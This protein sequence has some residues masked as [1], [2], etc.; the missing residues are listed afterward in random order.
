MF[1]S[2]NPCENKTCGPYSS[3]SLLNNVPTCLCI[4]GYSGVSGA[5][6]DIDECAAS[7]CAV[8]A[9]CVNEPGSFS[10]QCPAGSLGDPFK[11]GCSTPK[12]PP[13]CGPKNPCPGSEICVP[14]EYLGTSVCVCS[15]GYI[16]D[17]K[18]GLCRDMNEC[19]EA[20][21][22]RPVC[23]RNAVC[24][25][26]PGSYECACPPGFNGNPFS[27]CE[28]CNTLECQ[29]RPPYQIA[30][31]EC[32]L[33][34]C[35]TQGQCPGGAEC[36]NIAGGVSYCACPKGFRPKEDGYCEDVDECAESRHLCGPGAV[37]INHPGSYT[38]QC[39]PN[40]S[41][42]PLLGCTHARV[43]CSRDAD[44]D[45]PYER[46]V[47][48]ACV[49][50]APYYADV[51]D[52]HKCK[53]PCER[54]SCGINAQCTPADPPQCTC[55]AGYT[56]EATVGC[57]DVDECLGVSPCASSALCVNEK[58]GFKCVCPKGT[59][60]DPYTLGCVGS[61]SPRTECRVD[62]ECSPSL[63]CRGGACVDPCRSVECGAH[64]LCEP[65][66]HRASCRCELGYTE[67]LNGKCVSLCEGIVCAPGAA[68]IVTPAG[69]TCTCADGAR[70]NPF[71]GGACYPDLCSATQPCPALSVCVAGRCK[72]RCAGVVCGAGAQC[73][74]ALDRCVCPP[75]YVGDPEFNCVPPV[76]MPVCIPP[77]G[78]NAHCEYN[79]ESP[80]SSPG[81]DNICVCNSG[82][83]GNPYAGC[84][85]AGP[86][87]RGS[88][89]SGAGLCGPGAQCLETGGSVECQCPA[90]Y[91]GNPYV[92]CVDIDECWS[93]NTCGSNAVCINT[94]GSYDCRCKEGNAGN[95]FVACTPVAVVPHSCE[96]PAT[97]VCSKNAPC[98]SGYVCKN[99]R[100]TDLCANV[101]CGPRALCV[102]GQCLCPSDLI[103][104]PTDLTRG[105]QVKGQCA[106][107]LECKPNEICF[108][109]NGKTRMCVDSCAKI[110]CGPNAI[111]VGVNHVAS[112]MCQDGYQGVPSDL[113]IG[114]QPERSAPKNECTKDQ[115]CSRG[116]VCNQYPET[117]YRKCVNLCTSTACGA[118][119]VC[120]V[121]E[122][123]APVCECK[124]GYTWNALSSACEL[125]SLPQC[126][127]NK[128]C[129]DHL[130]CRPDAL[131]ILQ[132][133]NP[134]DDFQCPGNSTCI[135]V[136][137][138]GTCS[139]LPG[140]TG[141]PEV[142]A[143]CQPVPIDTCSSDQQCKEH[144]TCAK[145]DLTGLS[146]CQNSCDSVSCGVNAV[147]VVNNHEARCFCPPGSY[148]GDP[149]IEC[150]Q[151]PCVHN[152]DCST[153]HACDL[154]SHTCIPACDS[155]ACGT[156]AVCIPEDHRPVCHCPV[157][158]HPSP[159]PDIH[160]ARESNLCRDSNPCHPTARC[161][162][163]GATNGKVV[164][165]CPELSVGDPYK[166]GCVPQGQC[167]RGDADCPPS[168]RCSGGQCVS[169]CQ[170]ACGPNALC[171]AVGKRPVCA[172]PDGFSAVGGEA[173]VGCFREMSACAGDQECLA[174][175]EKCIGG[176]CRVACLSHSDCSEGERC[177]SS[178]CQSPCTSHSQCPTGQACQAG[179]CELGC[180][181][182]EEC[183]GQ[184]ICAGSKCIDP[185]TQEGICGP[186]ALCSTSNHTVSC[187]C[188]VGFQGHPEPQQGCV[189]T[190]VLCIGGRTQCPSGHECE[191]GVCKKTCSGEGDNEL[192]CAMGE[193]CIS[194]RC[195]KIC[196][197][198]ANCLSGE[199][200]RG[201]VCIPGC[202]SDQ[203][204]ATDQICA[205]S[206]CR[207]GPGFSLT[208][209]GCLDMDECL[210][211]PCHKSA[212]CIN[213][214]GSFR[215]VCKPNT[216]G[217][218][219]LNPGCVPA[220]GCSRASDCNATLSCIHR[221]C[222]DPCTVPENQCGPNALCDVT[223]HIPTCTCPEGYLGDPLNMDIGCFRVEC[224]HPSHCAYDRTCD[225]ETNRCINPCDKATCGNGVCK[226]ANHRAVCSCAPGFS[227]VNNDC[228]D[229]N[230]CDLSPCHPTAL[231]KNTAGSFVC[232]CAGGLIGDPTTSGCHPADVCSYD[233]QCP[234]SAACVDGRCRNPCEADEVCGRN[235]ECAVVNH[236]PRCTCVAG[237]VGD[238]K[239]GCVKLECTHS[240]DCGPS[241]VCVSS[242]CVDPCGLP[243]SCGQNAACRADK[244]AAVCTCAED[245]TGDPFLGC[246]RLLYCSGDSQCPTGTHCSNGLCSASCTSSRDCIGEQQCISGLC[247]PT[248]RSN[249]T[250]P[251]QHYCNSGL[252]VPE[253]Q[254]T[255]HDQCSAT[256]QCRSNDM[257]QM[258]CRPACEGILCGR[259]ALCTASDHHATCSCKPGYVGHPG[260]SMGTGPSSHSGHAG[261]KHGPGLSPGAT[262]HSSHS[263]GPVGCHRVECNS[264]ADCSGDKV[265]ED[266][267]CKISCLANNPCGP[268]ALCSAEKHKQICY[269]QPGYTGDAYFGCHLIDFCAAKPCGPGARCDNSRGSYKCLCPLGLVGDPYGAGC[270]SASQCTRDDQCPPG[271]HCVK[272]D[273]VPKCK[274]A[275][276]GV[277]C[278]PNADCVTSDHTS[279]CLC[280]NGYEGNPSDLT[281]GCRP[282]PL[283]CHTNNDCPANY[284]CYGELCRTSCQSDEECGLGEKCLQGQC[285]NP[286]ERQG[287]CGVN[288]LCNVLTHRKVCFCPRGFTGD[289]ETECVRMPV[290]CEVSK[291]CP[292]STQHVCKDNLCIPQCS[293]DN[294]CALNE[295][296]SNGTCVLTCLSHADCYPGGGSLCLANLCTR[297]CSADTDCPAALSCRS[298][299][300]VDPCSPAPCGPNAQC[301]VANHRPLCSCPAGLMGLPSANTACVRTPALECEENRQCKG[302]GEVCADG[303]CRPLCSSD[304]GCLSNE[305][306][307]TAAGVCKPLC[308]RDDDCS[309]GEVCRGLLCSPGCRS[310]TGCADNQ[311]C[312][313]NSCQDPCLSPTACGTNAQ[314]S[315]QHHEKQCLCPKP[316][317]GDPN[318]AC[319]PETRMCAIKRDCPSGS[320]CT[321]GVCLAS[322]KSDSNCLTDER[323][324]K[325]SC[326][327]ICNS[328]SKCDSGQICEDR[329]CVPGCRTDSVCADNQ[330]CVNKQC[331]DPCTLNTTCGPCSAC[332]TLNHGPQCT[333]P[334][335]YSGHPLL[336]CTPS[337]MRCDGACPCDE[338]SGY[339]ASM[340]GRDEECQ[341]GE[342]CDQGRCR[343]KCTGGVHSACP[344][345]QICSAGGV[346]Q[347]GCRVHSDC[348]Q[349]KSCI[350]GQC[351]DPCAKGS[352]GDNLRPTCGVDALCR[353]VEHRPV[354]LC[355]D[356]YQGDPTDR[357]E[358]Y[359]CK[360]DSDCEPGK[361]CRGDGVCRNP[362][363][364]SG[365]CG[366]NAQCRVLQRHAWRKAAQPG[367]PV[368]TRPSVPTSVG[369]ECPALAP[370]AVPGTPIRLVCV[371][372]CP[373][374]ASVDRMPT[375]PYREEDR[376]FAG[377]NTEDCRVTGCGRGALCTRD[378]EG[379]SCHCPSGTSGSP[380][381][382]CK[383]A[384]DVNMNSTGD[385][386][387]V[388]S[389]TSTI[390]TTT[391]TTTPT[392]YTSALPSVYQQQSTSTPCLTQPNL[393]QS[394]PNINFNH[395]K[396]SFPQDGSNQHQSN[397]SLFPNQGLPQD[398]LSQYNSNPTLTSDQMSS[399]ISWQI[400]RSNKRKK[401]VAETSPNLKLKFKSQ[402]PDN[403][404][405][406]KQHH[407][408]T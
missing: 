213:T 258:Q 191:D 303:R 259:N 23:G 245:Y 211:R 37:C 307:D 2:L 351:R 302:E 69:P 95:P 243:N 280:R 18:S 1:L 116:L 80:G 121:D 201:G 257:G 253:M 254:C 285:N 371:L 43:Q 117:G 272:T 396:Q 377:R 321:D 383:P 145:D 320:T 292:S 319:R 284:Y 200:C 91:K 301:S 247:Q 82:T 215:C 128:D 196:Y 59:T 270:V 295:K 227:L 286:C 205:G 106:N 366:V 65:Q 361:S 158:T 119:E 241:Q 162:D 71:P 138:E 385:L 290:P 30:S 289:P 174:G 161:E 260:P 112:C 113:N 279:S 224:S 92:Q 16:R 93:S 340:C 66:D 46:C 246:T 406:A 97:C 408:S 314:C 54:F 185:C 81:N 395:S 365:V 326:Q 63:Q 305:R 166:T 195:E 49:C 367:T 364:T 206:K 4:S 53:S 262:S 62:K 26:L 273:G 152:H 375:A 124:P 345:G 343:V 170:G 35:G 330:A 209:S 176:R 167:P 387:V 231:C 41:G 68:C 353:V 329:L 133:S 348:P 143:G 216:V 110:Q 17:P 252:C 9:V 281:V 354:C 392:G 238:P 266:H 308:H 137:H 242:K 104:N 180:R 77:C 297:G 400:V 182:N 102:Q 155:G 139:C 76:T 269:C 193:R 13:G 275:C 27:L 159:S 175:E 85:T 74:P 67:G 15:R 70:G 153:S 388:C 333:C 336:A 405:D 233:G 131:G 186:N 189:R 331:T 72:A 374:G 369:A 160:C 154:L 324:I 337:P 288:S 156:N 52:G 226:A 184:M 339:C 393:Y 268:N 225:P 376:S 118:N 36:V 149:N 90:G 255:T 282:R 5:C 73:D 335:G 140:F 249:T 370:Q 48:A 352:P 228:V 250:C 56:G 31:G 296:C 391:V 6:A 96:D 240:T 230:E 380:S 107:D 148:V 84:G 315:V 397:P 123:G 342:K 11:E 294:D 390:C 100:C 165:S 144:E 265:C 384:D 276:E 194:N 325:A 218:P 147:C 362:C 373:Q 356:N 323:C 318:I 341:C 126:T 311:A 198:A 244:H 132:C 404:S 39:P 135:S 14:D 181:Q 274:G 3:C 151:V 298:A 28:E 358:S 271:A 64:A 34:T 363:L 334:L 25:N 50:P 115:D 208:P 199:V 129:Q 317:Q 344:M 33:A 309:S 236:T 122:Q 168:S 350:D 150:R 278:G 316:L 398:I 192:S 10:C 403:Q 103:G 22:S 399:Q 188:P 32:T 328:D 256:E 212:S 251:A 232:S 382:E 355:P 202:S 187:S 401:N 378:E 357:C 287:A 304:G 169:V 142:R 214:P 219:Y 379:Y 173:R 114:C 237:T 360:Q 51:N 234:A 98:P 94:P 57:L 313:D 221:R 267:R 157:G 134:C 235:A 177:L 38:C 407:K 20:R 111:C 79:S 86:Q 164:C 338:T 19:T 203:D 108:Q 306:C 386:T 310:D 332:R 248:C 229:V 136:N 42:D 44:C 263:G 171:R 277:R 300:C 368:G 47:R 299:E 239:S 293:G 190:P 127:A 346:C 172:C 402:Q 261:G 389:S 349:D 12:N 105:C 217:D 327:T 359:R 45:G 283:S 372:G 130:A 178:L 88:C 78:P 101:R 83:H 21:D 204:C 183:S 163:T 291:D 381:L 58:G 223:D 40:S 8:G 141:N 109:G 312:V 210:T 87:D 60:G 120:T 146:Q 29:C 125:P 7:P 264:H 394:Q 179:T 220:L 222:L 24:K 75:F 89:D 55:L 99:S 197:A 207:C 347:A 322:C 61:G